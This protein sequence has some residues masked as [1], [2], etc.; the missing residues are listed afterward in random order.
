M[1]ITR[2]DAEVL[3]FR[4]DYLMVGDEADVC[5]PGVD[6]A[7]RPGVPVT[8]RLFRQSNRACR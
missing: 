5:A 1:S 2:L 4:T 3:E 8:Y 6:L 7:E